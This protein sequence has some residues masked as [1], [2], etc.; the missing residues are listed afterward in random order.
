VAIKK[1]ILAN[2]LGTGVVTIAPILALPWYLSLLGS[3]QYG[4]LG[5]IATLQAVLT[6]IDAGMS[7]ALVREFSLRLD[8]EKKMVTNAAVILFGFERIYCIFSILTA[9]VVI[10]FAKTIVIRWLNLSNLPTSLGVE[11]VYGAAALFAIQ[12]PGSLYR[13]LLVGAQAQ[14]KLNGIMLSSALCRHIGA[15]I[16]LF[17]WPTLFA[18]LLWNILI[19]FIE[20]FLR[21]RLAWS[22]L[23]VNRKVIHWEIEMLRPTWLKI[24]NMSAAT[25]LGALTVQIDKIVLVKMVDIEQFGY[26]VIASTVATGLLQ[27]IYPLIQAVLPRAIQLRKNPINI[28]KL[29]IKLLKSIAL[30]AGLVVFGYVFFGRFVLTLW[31]KSDLVVGH[32]YQYLAILLVG[33][34]LNAFY[35]IG[36]MN[37][38]ANE[39]TKRIIQ[40]NALSLLLAIIL[41]PMLII[42]Y[43]TIGA[44]FSWIIINLI[45][46]ILSLEWVRQK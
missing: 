38:I 16:I 12:F 6:I 22:T 30:I 39:Q 43:G 4:L 40:V 29:N 28:Y 14:V 44:A 45:G 10:I 11:A 46:L 41:A 2:Y 13:S 26:Y 7:Q 15:V 37:W 34:L 19:A 3:K 5:F 27:L 36:Y 35:N 8:I 1:N 9:C 42:K 32:V 31:L 24:A 20:T 18:Y 17:I 21:A 33:T 23:G 25:F